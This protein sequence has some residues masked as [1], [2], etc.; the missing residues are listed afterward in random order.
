M[1]Y[2]A[3]FSVRGVREWNGRKYDC[4]VQQG[5]V[6]HPYLRGPGPERKM[7]VTLSLKK[8]EVVLTLRMRTKSTT[9]K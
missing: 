2:G 8:M 3:F 6:P 7:L 4:Y 5:E 1:R 9:L